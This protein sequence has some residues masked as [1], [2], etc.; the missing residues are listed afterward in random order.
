MDTPLEIATDGSSLVISPVK[1]AAREKKISRLP[2]PGGRQAR[3][4][5]RK[6]GQMSEPGF[7]TLAEVLEI[8]KDQIERYGGAHGIRDIGLVESA[9]AMPQAG[10]GG[11]YLLGPDPGTNP[12]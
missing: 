6:T 12:D 9:L 11:E 4:N 7:L 5:L 1:D 8:H 3:E 10:F 2:G